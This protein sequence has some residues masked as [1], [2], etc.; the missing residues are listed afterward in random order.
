MTVS[1]KVSERPTAVVFGAGSVGRGFLGQLFTE[2]GYQVVFV[3]VDAALVAALTSRAAYTLRLSGIDKTEDLVIAPVRAVDGRETAAVAREVAHA[4]LVATAVGARALPA[5][6]RPIAQGLLLR[7]QASHAQSLNIIVCENLHDAPEQ[8]SGFV[9]D[10]L[11]QAE[12]MQ[13]TSRVGFVP[14]VIARM[15]PVPTPEQRAADITLVVAEPYK[16]LP[17][18][19][20]AF[21]GEVP[22]VAGLFPV[23]P[24]EAYTA[25]K[26]FIHNAAH[27]MLGYLGAYRGHRY[28]YEALDDAWVHR[29]VGQALK[30]SSRA[31]VSAFGFEPVALQ[32]HIDYL[33]LRFSNRALGDPVSRLARDPLRKLAPNDRLVGAARLAERYGVESQGL[34]WGIAGAL[35]YSDPED[36]HAVAMQARVQAEGAA[37]VL[38]EVSGISAGEDLGK[39][40]LAHYEALVSDRDF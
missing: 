34:A 1:G 14:A 2:S 35:T 10:A 27:A 33:L 20:D 6:A 30:E 39:L 13:L 19:R 22:D 23:A 9:V 29:R 11:P 4:A 31:L 21:V 12:R 28:G 18:S 40:V 5:I 15:A 8:L 16:V 36:P 3:D 37:R 24:F 25:R 32:E 26:L 38:S 17:V 7:W